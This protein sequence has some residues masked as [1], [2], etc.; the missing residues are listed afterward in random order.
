MSKFVVIIFSNEAK[1]YQ[2]IRAL[3]LL[4]SEGS[5][6]LYATAV[7]AKDADGNLSTKES[8][9][10]GPLGTAVGALMGALLG[11]LAGPVGAAAG[12]AGGAVLGG[13]RDLVVAGIS[14]DFVQMV[15]SELT[16]GNVVVVAEVSEDWVTPLDSHMEPLGGVVLRTLRSDFED[17]QIK[18]TVA[19]AKA[20][21][22][23]LKTEFEAAQA[24]RLTKV[25]MRLDVA[26]AR[27]EHAAAEA[28]KKAE[29]LKG[30]GEARVAELEKQAQFAIGEKKDR[31]DARAAA[32]TADYAH[33]SEMLR[34]AWELAKKAL[35]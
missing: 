9:P 31:F 30:D 6:V 4:H 18:K 34:Q 35:S 13:I 5:L 14:A 12:F 27:F 29:T 25:K 16:L 2:G 10:E 20:E 8:A 33:R 7:L 17:E 28:K 3:K 21:Y 32:M 11:L 26:K 19:A 22:E 15:S 24:G 1:A 23:H